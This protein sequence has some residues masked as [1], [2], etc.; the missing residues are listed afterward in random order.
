M[1]FLFKVFVSLGF[2]VTCVRATETIAIE[3]E[4]ST[5]TTIANNEREEVQNKLEEKETNEIKIQPI[6]SGHS[7]SLW[8]TI[9][10]DDDLLL[11]EQVLVD[12]EKGVFE[13]L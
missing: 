11:L 10:K 12:I 7:F 8:P 6:L 13:C 4:N 9:E 3:T 1:N 2:L 5:E